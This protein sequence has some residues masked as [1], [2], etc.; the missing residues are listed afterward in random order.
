MSWTYEKDNDHP[1]CKCSFCD[2][3][4]TL[5]IYDVNRYLFCPYCGAQ[6]TL[7]PEE[8]RKVTRN[9]N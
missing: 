6:N 5:N 9:D 8:Y 4:M 1:M 2:K 7:V 3:R